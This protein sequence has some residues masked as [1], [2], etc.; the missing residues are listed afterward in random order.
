MNIVPISSVSMSLDSSMPIAEPSM[1]LAERASQAFARM[2][3]DA[4]VRR[5]A[6]TDGINSAAVTNPAQL[7]EMQMAI[8]NYTLDISLASTLARKAVSTVETLVKAQ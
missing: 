7:Y 4:D 2:S 3:V 1:G 5:G 8:A 6:V